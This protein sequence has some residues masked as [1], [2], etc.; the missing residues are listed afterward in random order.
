MEQLVLTKLNSHRSHKRT[1]CL[2]S[3]LHLVFMLAFLLVSTPALGQR[4]AA[5]DPISDYDFG[6]WANAGSLSLTNTTCATMIRAN[7]SL[8]DY[9][10]RVSDLY[11][12]ANGNFYLYLDGDNSSTSLEVTVDHMDISEGTYDSLQEN[13]QASDDHDS[14]ALNCPSEDNLYLRVNIAS[15]ELAGKPGGDYEGYFE[16]RV[17]R[18]NALATENFYVNVT[19][20]A[21]PEVQISHLDSVDFGQHSGLGDLSVTETF[22]VYSSEGSYNISVDSTGRTGGNHYL[23]ATS[24]GDTIPLA[25]LFADNGTGPGTVQLNSNTASGTGHTSSTDCAGTDNASLT[26]QL[27]ESDLQAAST[28]TYSEQITILIVPE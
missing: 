27:A 4:Q 3:T 16:L 12:S 28:G 22:C 2:L 17:K 11:T 19:V 7:G 20:A 1:I 5:L 24:G 15:S 26:F 8:S 10:V 13:I 21:S 23:L 25:I 9:R 18:G 14:P 6:S